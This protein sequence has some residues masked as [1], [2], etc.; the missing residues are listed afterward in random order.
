MIKMMEEIENLKLL[1]GLER[2]RQ[3]SRLEL[4]VLAATAGLLACKWR[5]AADWYQKM[6]RFKDR[7]LAANSVCQSCSQGESLQIL[8]LFQPFSLP[9]VSESS[10][11][12]L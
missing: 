6:S 8:S 9:K 2:H 10:F 7:A 4:D 12:T 1:V 5:E 3:V 11:L